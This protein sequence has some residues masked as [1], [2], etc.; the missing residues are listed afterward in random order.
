MVACETLQVSLAHFLHETFDT[1]ICAHVCMLCY[2][3]TLLLMPYITYIYK[4]ASVVHLLTLHPS[5]HKRQP[6]LWRSRPHSSHLVAPG[7]H[8]NG[9]LVQEDKLKE[10]KYFFRIRKIPALNILNR[11]STTNR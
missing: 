7:F 6:A 10:A 5:E 3:H 4:I 2:A 9:P 8:Q 1:P 11:M